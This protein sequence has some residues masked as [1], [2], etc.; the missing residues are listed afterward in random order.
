MQIVGSPVAS[1]THPAKRDRLAAIT[2]GYNDR[3]DNAPSTPPDVTAPQRHLR[4]E[5]LE[6]MQAI[7]EQT[8]KE[9]QALGLDANDFAPSAP[10]VDV[11]LFFNAP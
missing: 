7:V 11:I 6:A 2:R 5:A 1:A 3:L 8:V 9:L 10:P 4:N